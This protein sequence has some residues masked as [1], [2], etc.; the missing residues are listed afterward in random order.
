MCYSYILVFLVLD[1]TISKD[2]KHNGE[3]QHEGIEEPWKDARF[4][5]I[6]FPIGKGF[7]EIA[8]LQCHGED[9]KD[10]HAPSDG[11]AGFA[12]LENHVAEQEDGRKQQYRTGD[13]CQERSE[14][15]FGKRHKSFESA[16]R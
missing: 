14:M 4:Y 3:N 13:G 2:V 7:P 10:E 16:K 6:T 5:Y 8:Q 1:S 12:L 15:A 11:L 9:E